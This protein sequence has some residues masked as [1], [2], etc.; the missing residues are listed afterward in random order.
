M[1][2]ADNRPHGFIEHNARVQPCQ[3]AG[4]YCNCL[5]CAHPACT[6][7]LNLLYFPT[8]Q[9]ETNLP[10]NQESLAARLAAPFGRKPF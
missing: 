1:N 4:I 10:E 8:S 6:G 3:L 9:D 7:I 2:K 5:L